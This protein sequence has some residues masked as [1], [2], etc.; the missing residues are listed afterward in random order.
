MSTSRKILPSVLMLLLSSLGILLSLAVAIGTFWLNGAEPASSADTLTLL[1]IGCLAIFIGLLNLPSLVFAI[2]KIKQQEIRIKN[3]SLFKSA[4]IAMIPW[5]ILLAIGFFLSQS[6]SASAILPP[7]TILTTAIP[8]WWLVEFSRRGLERPS[9]SKEWGTLTLGLI[10][11]PSLIMI[12]EV[13]F[14]IVITLVVLIIL[15]LQPGVL[16]ELMKFSGSLG[17]SQGGLDELDQLLFTLAEDPTIATAIFL[18]IGVVA[19]FTE[20][21][22]KPLSVWL[23][24]RRPIEPRDGFTLGLI[25][26]G[27]FTLLESASL[28]SQITAQEWLMAIVLRAGTGILHIGLSGLTGYGIARAKSEKRWGLA[29]L[30]ILGATALH[31]LWNSMALLNGY[32]ALP[33]PGFIGSSITEI[34]SVVVMA[35]VFI[36]IVIITIKINARLRKEQAS[37]I[38][39]THKADFIDQQTG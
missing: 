28:V 38:F 18:V 1:S 27:A 8:I 32:S 29:F 15:G 21:V 33:M 13:L 11:A 6:S 7:V 17:V 26:G 16:T 3:P 12:I 34:F 2:K 14:V 24:L 39:A 20:E 22:F 19:P 31:G 25:S 35:G 5:G 30:Y 4:C 37:Q 10:L 36:A 23:R 9:P